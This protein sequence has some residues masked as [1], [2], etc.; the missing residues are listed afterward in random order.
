[1]LGP[2]LTPKQCHLLASE[3]HQL[4]QGQLGHLDILVV[5]LVAERRDH[6]DLL[7]QVPVHE[8]SNLLAHAGVAVILL[9]QVPLVKVQLEDVLVD[10]DD[11]PI[12]AFSEPS[13]PGSEIV[14]IVVDGDI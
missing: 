13:D 8:V 6:R 3:R 1:M 14:L 11:A 5:P 12:R 9:T 2:R 4:L 10:V 7:G